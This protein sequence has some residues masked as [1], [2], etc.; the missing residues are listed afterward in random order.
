M[1]KREHHRALERLWLEINRLNLFIND[2]APWALK[3]DVPES[4]Q[5]FIEVVYNGLYGIDVVSQILAAFLPDTGTKALAS[6]GQVPG[7]INLIPR[8]YSLS[9]PPVLFPRIEKPKAPTE[10]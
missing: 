10:K 9:D 7:K 3:D 1:Q 2:Q 4:R 8:A 6:L 5:K